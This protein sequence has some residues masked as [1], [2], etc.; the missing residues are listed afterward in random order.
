MSFKD[1]DFRDRDPEWD[2]VLV[3]CLEAVENGDRMDRQEWLARYPVF[4]GQ[5]E[6]FFADHECLDQLAAPLRPVAQRSRLA[7]AATETPEAS[8]G[9]AAG[10]GTTGGSM[11]DYDLLEEIGRGGMG[12][13]HK[14]RQRDLNRL[15]ALKRIPP[16]A[17]PTA[18][19]V[20]RFRVEAE[21]VARLDHPHIVPIY[22]VG[23]HQG[24]PYFSMK[25][26]EGGSLTD[27][28]GQFRTDPR[29]AARLVIAIG[30]AVHHA[31]QR[32]ILHR[33]LKPS[34]ILLDA[35]GRPHVTDFGLAKRLAVGDADPTTWEGMAG[36]PSYMAPEQASG[37]RGS[38]TTATDVYG[39]GTILYALLTERKPFAGDTP[40]ETIDQVR[41]QEPVP[42]SRVNPRVDRDLETICLKCLAKE[43]QGRYASAEALAEDL[44]RW[45]ADEP[46]Q[47]R[48]VSA[49]QRG[50]KW[51]RRRPLAVAAIALVILT[52]LLLAGGAGWIANDRATRRMATTAEV[53]KALEESADRQRRRQV[54]EALSAARRA[55]GVLA[56]GEAD[57]ALSREVE[58]RLS[59]F[60]LLAQLE[61]VRVEMTACTN[62]GFDLALGDRRYGE[63]FRGANLDI[64]ALSPAEAAER[65]RATAVVAELAAALYDWAS[66]R[67]GLR[68][69]ED[70]TWKH[71]LEVARAADRDSWRTRLRGAL[72]GNDRKALVDLAS[73]DRAAEL[74]PLTITALFI[75]L[76]EAGAV[77]Q[78]ETLLRTAQRRHPDS[79][80]IN[81]NLAVFLLNSQPART[82]EAIAYLR[83]AVALRPESAWAR[84]KLGCALGMNGD[85]DGA[86]AECRGAIRLN[87]R[88]A[89]AHNNL[90][91]AL[92]QKGD[93]DGA[94]DAYRES[95]RLNPDDVIARCNLGSALSRK[96]DVEGGIG[97]CRA[98]VHL[99]KDNPHSHFILGVALWRK[100]DLDG[101]MAEY[102]ET[103]RLH[104]PHSSAYIA[105]G[106]VFRSKGQFTESLAHYRRGYE[107]ETSPQ[108][109]S[110]Y[111]EQV[112]LGERLV[113]LDGKL[114]RILNGE[115]AP[116]DAAESLDLAAICYTP[117]QRRYG[118]AVRFYRDAFAEQPRLAEDFQRKFRYNAACTAALAGC[119]QGKDA[120]K[121][122][123]EQ[124]ANLRQ[125]ALDWLRADLAAC[126]KVLEGDR[127]KAATAVRQQ[128]Q[129]W[130]QDADFAGV[131]GPHALA[132]LPE[133][134]RSAWRK[135]WAEVEELLV[136]AGGKSSGAEK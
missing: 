45:L 72:E 71:I 9:D 4:A 96:G 104:K 2:E 80:W 57:L 42:P 103:I 105:L 15:V 41:Q 88:S 131:R 101:A 12:V 53:R 102:R 95:V 43:P 75:A 81:Y 113:E 36:T 3:A 73:A 46:I 124:R 32:G 128:M 85:V 118:A 27:R 77:E 28:L 16:A 86:I 110:R 112:K 134:E 100:G 10:T 19:Q 70:T 78:G 26:M 59:E 129:H 21:T 38:I 90:G 99:D 66:V 136:Q 109:R 91:A 11:G 1:T 120:D 50:M 119:G 14:A 65:I 92:E 115:A 82:T 64:D 76:S 89:T 108:W 7:D 47:A 13:V 39:L 17:L 111:A 93:V 97:E 49:W 5:L 23:E 107:L 20:R 55:M 24:Q 54:P 6:E 83:A 122:G 126:H 48:P 22:D 87:K 61:D 127:A 25:L 35:E 125:Q 123:N 37:S 62:K 116:G 33:D 56:G 30:R 31:H 130:L 58:A 60:E 68:P 132:K 94:I 117:A 67:R 63:L 34:N 98:A 40:L 133:A 106:D 74:L 79:F 51:A 135:V 18:D 69:R 8:A 44:E 84:G 114:P 52:A 29:S 121:L